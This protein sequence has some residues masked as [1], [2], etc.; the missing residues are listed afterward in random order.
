VAGGADGRDGP[1]RKRGCRQRRGR[2]ACSA[3][4]VAAAAP[5]CV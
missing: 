2:P 1:A 5:P 3:R 4:C